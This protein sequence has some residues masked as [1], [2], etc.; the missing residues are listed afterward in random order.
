MI[1]IGKVIASLIW[2]FWIFVIDSTAEGQDNTTEYTPTY[3]STYNRVKER[4]N[5][6]C[7]T[8]DEFPGFSQE[9][10]SAEDG[11]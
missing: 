9:I 5:V 3:S 8:N 6:I 1:M 10:W 11:S 2:V 7:G 4:G